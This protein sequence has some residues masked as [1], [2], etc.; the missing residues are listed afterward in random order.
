MVGGFGVLANPVEQF[1]VFLDVDAGGDLV[2]GDGLHRGGGHDAAGDAHGLQRDVT[3]ELGAQEI[4]ANG[5]GLGRGFGRDVDAAG[6][7]GAEDVHDG[8]DA[9]G[10]CQLE[11]G[12]GEKGD[13]GDGG[14]GGVQA[15]A[16][17][18]IGSD[19]RG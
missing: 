4:E 13:P 3:V 17:A 2:G 14:I 7:L 6:A 5:G 16:G 1:V 18:H 15:G 12:A 9:G 10:L 19:G 8:G 11:V